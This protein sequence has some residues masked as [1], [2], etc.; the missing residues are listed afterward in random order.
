[1]LSIWCRV[2]LL[3]AIHAWLP[4]PAMQVGCQHLLL[5]RSGAPRVHGFGAKG[6]PR[7]LPRGLSGVWKDNQNHLPMFCR[8][9]RH[10]VAQ[11]H[12]NPNDLK[13]STHGL[14]KHNPDKAACQAPAEYMQVAASLEHRA[15]NTH[16]IHLARTMHVD[17][18]RVCAQ[19][20]TSHSR[21]HRQ[22][23][24]ASSVHRHS[25]LLR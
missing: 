15:T 16:D 18:P 1:M 24:P 20:R 2:A 12:P 6:A 3:H 11:T 25:T 9:P 21:L 17:A 5:L 7:N 22:S 14:S 10:V 19:C 8:S 4:T 23:A 13:G